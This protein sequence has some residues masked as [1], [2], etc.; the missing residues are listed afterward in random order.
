VTSQ[1]PN[2]HVKG[3]VRLPRECGTK[4]EELPEFWRDLHWTASGLAVEMTQGAIR[5]VAAEQAF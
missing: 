3:T 4:A 1:S 2:T 5:I